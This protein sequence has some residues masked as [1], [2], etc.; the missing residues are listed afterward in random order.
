MHIF[1][2][3]QS[4]MIFLFLVSTSTSVLTDEANETTPPTNADEQVSSSSSSSSSPAITSAPSNSSKDSIDN[5]SSSTVSECPPDHSGEHR[6]KDNQYEDYPSFDNADRPY[7]GRVRL[8]DDTLYLAGLQLEPMR[9]MNN[10]LCVELAMVVV[11]GLIL[12]ASN[13]I[14]TRRQKCYYAKI[15]AAWGVVHGGGGGGVGGGK[16][17]SASIGTTAAPKKKSS[18]SAQPR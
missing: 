13:Y 17:E 14:N 18:I 3:H 2:H 15:H 10:L 1:F 9:T 4:L 6:G 16:A 12:S 5:N 8:P 7:F 11:F